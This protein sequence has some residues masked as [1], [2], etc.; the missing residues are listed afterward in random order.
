MPDALVD[1]HT[2]ARPDRDAL[3]DALD[4]HVVDDVLRALHEL[5][6][7]DIIVALPKNGFGAEDFTEA[8]LALFQTLGDVDT[9]RARALAGLEDAPR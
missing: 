3:V 8:P 9:V 6:H 1:F 4:R 7:E 5:L 2:G